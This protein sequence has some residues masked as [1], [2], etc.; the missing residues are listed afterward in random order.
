VLNEQLDK[1]RNRENKCYHKILA[2]TKYLFLKNPMNLTEK[3]KTRLDELM[4]YQHLE[5]VQSF[6]MLLE[7]KKLFDYKSPSYVVK[8]FERWFNGILLHIK[9]RKIIII[10]FGKLNLT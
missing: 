8:F 3:E 5:T 6:S 9:T 10:A 1:V 4:R 7:F 2:R